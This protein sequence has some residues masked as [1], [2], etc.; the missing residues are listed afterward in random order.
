MVYKSYALARFI[1]AKLFDKGKMRLKIFANILMLIA[2][3]VLAYFAYNLYQ[4]KFGPVQNFELFKTDY[5]EELVASMNLSNEI[6]QFAKNMR[7]ASRE[8]TYFMDSNCDE[9]KSSRMKEAF[10]KI[11]TLTQVLSFTQISSEILADIVIGCSEDSFNSEE[12][13]FV[14]GE[15]GPSK[16]LNLSFYPKIQRGKIL[17]YKESECKE[18]ATEIHELLHVL[19][20]THI[21]KSD[22]IMYPYLNCKQE[23]DQEYIEYLQG[24]YSIPALAELY[25]ENVTASKSGIYLNMTAQIYNEGLLDAAPLALIVS[26]EG[27]QVSVLDLEAIESGMLTT[28]YANYLKLPSRSV[29]KIEL[30]IRYPKDEYSKANNFVELKVQD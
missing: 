10:S 25:F 18:P 22:S 8:L 24:L 27:K 20:F 6:S 14:L 26:A 30:E 15:G 7:F 23:I 21:N 3:V 9:K 16:F 17:L 13:I 1:T 4:D 11:A 5:Q 19:G 2:I 28:F 29:E 12:N